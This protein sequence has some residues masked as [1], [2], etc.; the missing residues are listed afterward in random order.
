M[1]IAVIGV[2][3]ASNLGDAVIGDC[4][5]YW[6]KKE[7]PDAKIDILDV[8]GKKEF[9]QQSSVSIRT[10]KKRKRKLKWDYWLTEKGIK[11]KVYYWNQLDVAQRQAFYDEVAQRGYDIAVFAGGQM[12][13]DWLSVD[14]CEFLKR[15]EQKRIPVFFNAC[16]VGFA[17]S[18]KIRNVL[19]NCLLKENVKLIS[20]RDDVHL[21]EN[22]YLN[23]KRNAILTYDPALWTKEV[24]NVEKSKSEYVGLGVMFCENE[25]IKKVTDFWV[26]MI[27]LLEQ[28]HIKWK[29]FCNGALDDYNYGC[30]VLEQMNLNVSECIFDYPKTPEEL[31]CQI[32]K[33]S[34]LISFR[35][36]SHIIATSLDIPAV[37]LVWDEKV[38]FFYQHL[39]HEERCK[40]IHDSA[41][42]VF[43]ALQLA[44]EQGYDRE[45]IEKQKNFA[46]QLLIDTINQEL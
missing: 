45:L 10:L 36:H 21:I 15:F 30:Y 18:E 40:T 35:L 14:V 23:G 22:R 19:S 7:Y 13:M 2:Y 25:N 24:Y 6:L 12:F 34:S 17:I 33:F 37:S 20:S 1:K 32:G 38:R 46:R 28:K 31:V 26:Q 11:D 16:G 44:K 41:E 43:M 42:S 29:M 9:P 5:S 4:V 39:G 3:Y 27:Q 8:E